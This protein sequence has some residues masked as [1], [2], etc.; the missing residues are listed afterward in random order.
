MHPSSLH[1]SSVKCTGH[2]PPRALRSGRL[3]A[4]IRHR[5]C[6]TQYLSSAARANT[7]ELAS[8]PGHVH[9]LERNLTDFGVEVRLEFASVGA[10]IRGLN[11]E[12]RREMRDLDETTRLEMCGL[13]DE[14]LRHMRVLCEDLVQ[15]IDNRRRQVTRSTRRSGSTRHGDQRRKDIDRFP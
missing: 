15:R 10:E 13:N 1:C 9:A 5:N 12:T 4:R 2:S 7:D 8:L 3:D 14:T 11:N 6:E